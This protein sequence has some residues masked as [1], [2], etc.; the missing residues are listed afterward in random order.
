MSHGVQWQNYIV[1]SVS[2]HGNLG[3]FPADKLRE[4][5]IQHDG[6]PAYHN[7]FD[8]AP[9]ETVK[10]YRGIIRPALGF[11]WIDFDSEADGGETAAEQML[12]ML[13]ILKPKNPVVFYSGFKGFA[14]G[15][16]ESMLG[17]PAP[18]PYVGARFKQIAMKLETG[19]FGLSTV[20]TG[21]YNH[22]RKWR[23]P[24]SY[25]PNS[26]LYKTPV[27]RALLAEK[28]DAKS[29]LA[30][31]KDLAK[32]R[33]DPAACLSY[34][35]E[36]LDESEHVL[37]RD[38]FHA[39]KDSDIVFEEDNK[40]KFAGF[41]DIENASGVSPGNEVHD[42]SGKQFARF[43]NK[44]CIE[45]MINSRAEDGEKHYVSVRVICDLFN[46]R[47][48]FDAALK[49]LKLWM[50][51]SGVAGDEAVLKNFSKI[52]GGSSRA[53][54]F[55]C[56]DPIKSKYC[57]GKCKIYPLLNPET[58][59]R[60]L[61]A[62]GQTKSI[63]ASPE[64][65]VTETSIAKQIIEE[66]RDGLIQDQEGNLFI[67]TGTHW[68]EAPEDGEHEA[69]IK[70]RLYNLLGEDARSGHVRS[71]FETL[72]TYVP[73]APNHIDLY[74]AHPFIANFKNGSLHLVKEDGRY[75]L[76]FRPHRKQDYVIN[77]LPYDYSDDWSEENGEFL[78]M[79]ERVFK[80]EA[81]MASRIRALGQM[82]GSC[83]LPAYPM[84]FTLH[85]MAGT[86][87]S[88]VLHL[89]S[90]FISEKNICRVPPSRM[91]GF[92]LESM[93]GKLVNIYNDIP[94]DKPIT[95]DQVKQI[96]DRIPIQIERKF[97]RDIKA[98]MPAIHIF[99]ANELPPTLDAS[100]R[101]H[102]RRW[103]FIGFDQVQAKGNYNKLYQD[104][105]FEQSPRGIL[106]FALRGLKDLL[107]SGGHFHVPASGKATMDKW[108]TTHD[109]IAVFLD[110]IEAGEVPYRGGGFLDSRT[111]LSLSPTASLDRAGLF[112]SFREWAEMSGY[113][114]SIMGSHAFYEAL[115]RKGFRYRKTNSRRV[116][117]G[118]GLDSR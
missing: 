38:F 35:D 54:E 21:N 9:C 69:R 81:D 80:G 87:K 117:D 109:V 10:G 107:E 34:M 4:K 47:T 16:P 25:N 24:A 40:Q 49:K 73:H 17:S 31:M 84:I 90:R 36:G 89:A 43:E 68:E 71:A 110:Q 1:P 102:E 88:T 75:S 118:F 100:S 8:F 15:V 62:P 32:V 99:G 72:K 55:G 28:L 77:V 83:L 82:F 93:A 18:S 96:F 78:T 74:S 66:S 13:N 85:G 29:L 48:P 111:R 12:D 19:I 61:D 46:T 101:A 23:L 86:G 26:K 95:D 5:I 79:L 39:G 65:K 33:P 76:E 70:Q 51:N 22:G 52:Y 94:I 7:I 20:D 60:V 14:I 106:N 57:S 3:H 42:E 11:Y 105:C 37:L 114:D 63:E 30:K 113:R 6:L 2:S 112:D 53:Y 67:Y 103:V 41:E 64:E 59:P 104:Y 92:K 116:I 56:K 98:L 50:K 115:A 97:R 27:P 45:K 91:F 44:K 108:L 58:R